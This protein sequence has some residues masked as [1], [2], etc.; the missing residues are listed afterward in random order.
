MTGDIRTP[1]PQF[2]PQ[3]ERDER[4]FARDKAEHELLEAYRRLKRGSKVGAF[5][6]L[7][8][9]LNVQVMPTLPPEV[10]SV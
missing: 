3:P 1:G 10:I 8:N 6:V 2:R 7:W 9:G 5:V 4:E